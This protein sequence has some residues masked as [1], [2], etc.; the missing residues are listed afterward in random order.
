MN[1]LQEVP[2]TLLQA[3]VLGVV[4]LTIF[5]VGAQWYNQYKL[6]QAT[7][8]SEQRK[9]CFLASTLCLLGCC[10]LIVSAV[11][12]Q[13]LLATQQ[14]RPGK[15]IPGEWHISIVVLA[16][17]SYFL[18]FSGWHYIV[19]ASLHRYHRLCSVQK[20]T[21]HEKLFQASKYT[22]TVAAI[23]ATL[24]NTVNVFVYGH[25]TFSVLVMLSQAWLVILDFYVNFSVRMHKSNP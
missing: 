8:N 7:P 22:T 16:V 11:Y 3:S 20:G 6:R 14:I 17:C 5:P 23:V 21:L 4:V 25:A 24:S 19:Q 18:L 10:E 12:Y 2:I 13:I 1:P 15:L 9:L